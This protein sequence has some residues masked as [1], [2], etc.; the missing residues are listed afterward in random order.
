MLDV[1]GL[2]FTNPR[3]L[4]MYRDPESAIFVIEE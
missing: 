1:G 4:R 3:V 2:I